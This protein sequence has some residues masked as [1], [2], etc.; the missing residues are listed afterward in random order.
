MTVVVRVRCE[1]VQVRGGSLAC[2][3]AFRCYDFWLL[4]L[5]GA[6]GP[7]EG[8]RSL[9]G[10]RGHEQGQAPWFRP[11]CVCLN[12]ALVGGVGPQPPPLFVPFKASSLFKPRGC[13]GA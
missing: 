9:C 11:V 1:V 10:G 8:L 12:S 4:A 7:S 13:M 5:W 2:L 6:P 3:P